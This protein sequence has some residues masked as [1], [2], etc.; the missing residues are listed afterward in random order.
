MGAII[1]QRERD[2]ITN[3]RNNLNQLMKMHGL[4]VSNFCDYIKGK[5]ETSLDRTTFTRFM[6][7][8]TQKVNIAFLISCSRAFEV[9]LDNLV[10]QNFNPNENFETIRAK[11]KD[12]IIQPFETNSFNFDHLTNEI[13]IENPNSSLIEKYIQPYYC[14]Y[15]STVA[16]EN[17][18]NNIKDSL[19]SGEL[20]IEPCGNKCKATLKINTKM[21]DKCGNPQFKIYS[22]NAVF[23]PSI[24]SVNCILALP[25]GEF[26]FIIFRYSHL[27]IKKQECRLAEVLSTS[28]TPDKRYPITHRMLLSNE[29]IREEDWEI[30]APHL[31]MNSSEILISKTDLSVLGKESE[32]YGRVVHEILQQ[33]SKSMYCVSENTVKEISKKYLALEELSLFITKLRSHSF[34]KRYNKVSTTADAEIRNVLLQKGYFQGNAAQF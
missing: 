18:T 27:N 3:V 20:N 1:L 32:S 34:A 10:S 2:I 15:Y 13:F 16:T 5:Q 23:C 11:Y 24:Q 7:G 4:T 29:K 30:I 8:T 28:S 25:E 9:S 14:Y 26:C 17:K 31:W 21:L 6:N 19:I 12:I 22:G 33:D